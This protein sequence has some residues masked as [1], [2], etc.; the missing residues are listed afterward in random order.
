MGAVLSNPGWDWD[1]GDPDYQCVYLGDVVDYL[2]TGKLMEFDEPGPGWTLETNLKAYDAIDEPDFFLL[3]RAS[4]QNAGWALRRAGIS[5]PKTSLLI[6]PNGSQ[7]LVFN[8]QENGR[9]KE[10]MIRKVGWRIMW[11]LPRTYTLL[12]LSSKI[13][14]FDLVRVGPADVPAVIHRAI[15]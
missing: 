11:G 6:L 2:Q 12:P 8:I 4:R 14:R 5:I 10:E 1:S 3:P 13:A 7:T 9:Q 15:P